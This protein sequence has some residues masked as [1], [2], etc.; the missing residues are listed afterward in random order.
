MAILA[1][2]QGTTG[3]TTVVF[4]ADGQPLAKAYREFTQLFP[5]PGWVEHDP[6]EIW[7]TVE[8]T[9][10]DVLSRTRTKIDA[11]GITNQRETTVLW[12]AKTGEPVCNA[13][14]WQCRRTAPICERLREFEPL[15]RRRTGLPLD[16]YFSGTKIR[17]A[18][19]NVAAAATAHLR[20]GTI[21]TWLIWKL[22]GG[23]VHATDP[24]NA[25]RTLLFDIHE[26]RW[27]S[28]LCRILGVPPEILPEVRGSVGN[29]GNVVSLP[30]LAGI[31]ILGV[32]GDQQAALFGQ[33]CFEPGEAKNTYGTGCFLLFNTGAHAID[34]HHGLLTTLAVDGRGRTCY[35]VEGSV[36]VAGAAVQ[37]LRDGLGLIRTAAESEAAARAVPDNGGVYL[38]PAFVGLGAPHWDPEVRGALVGITRG[39]SRKHVIRAAL[40][41]IAFQ[42]VDVVRAMEEDVGR[43]VRSLAVDGGAA[44]NDFL[45]QFQADVL[46]R[47]VQRPQII[48]TTSRGAAFLAGLGAGGWKD[49][50][51]LRLLTKTERTFVPSMASEVREALLKGWGKALRQVRTR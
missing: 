10:A 20:F 46:D 42:T 37:W 22:T 28:E 35:A 6:L 50:E 7:H 26:Q 34:S 29:F 44:A 14:V 32:A 31:P 3:T 51:T 5:Q 9:V 23:A 41:A 24:T 33:T 18:L 49:A 47:P 8:E 15:F 12:D 16:P 48:E 45:M 39:T 19:D 1:I 36:F 21:D 2:D 27:A 17:W 13:I 43:P 11:V 38:V 4:G 30:G 40:E 25:S